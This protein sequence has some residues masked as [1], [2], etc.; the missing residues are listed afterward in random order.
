MFNIMTP[1]FYRASE[2]QMLGRCYNF[3]CNMVPKIIISLIWSYSYALAT[4]SDKLS[5][6]GCK[7]QESIQ[8]STTPDPG[9][10][11][12]SDKLS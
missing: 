3:N 5:K 6:K 12:E 10:Q 7:D 9:Y 11:W 4:N 8:S 1:K 2:F